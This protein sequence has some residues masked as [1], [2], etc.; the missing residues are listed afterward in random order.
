MPYPRAASHVGFYEYFGSGSPIGHGRARTGDAEPSYPAAP[1]GHSPD[2]LRVI[3]ISSAMMPAGIDKWLT[4][5]VRHSDRRRLKFTRCIV[6]SDNVDRKQL[7]RLGVP[8]EIGGR[9]SIRRAAADCDVMLISDPGPDPDWVEDMRAKLCVIVAHGDGPWTRERLDRMAPVTDHV[10]AVSER[11]RRAVCNGFPSTV[12]P[13]GVDPLHL[14]R[15]RPRDAVRAS[16]GFQP[17]DFVVGFVGRFSP[18]KNPFAVIEAV[19]RLPLHFKALMVGFG[20]LRDELIDR[21]NALI[22]SRFTVVRGEDHLGDLYAAMD[23]FC[24]ASH[25]EG[26]GLAIMEAMMCGKPVIVARVGF[27]PEAITDRING[28]VVSGD[29]A[30]ISQAAALLDT[31][32]DWAASLGREAARYAER[33]G[34]ASTMADRYA[35]LLETL[36]S[37]RTAG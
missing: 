8:V 25:A 24:L 15:S 35:D 22:P 31:H 19:A 28:L 16:L 13:N 36:W 2:A 9:D 1:A 29:T 32:P 6:T 27:V 26:Y 30:S 18:E 3:H 10:V 7:A 14:T 23:A 21:A 4:G 33:H 20:H 17:G 37:A 5:L 11:V 12:I 34:Y